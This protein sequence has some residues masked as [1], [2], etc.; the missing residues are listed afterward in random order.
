ML[1][2]LGREYWTRAVTVIAIDDQGKRIAIAFRVPRHSVR[3]SPVSSPVTLHGCANC[4]R[5]PTSVEALDA[6]T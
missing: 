3:P 1:P 6:K 2:K 4:P 5:W